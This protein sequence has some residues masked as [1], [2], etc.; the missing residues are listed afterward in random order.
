MLSDEPAVSAGVKHQYGRGARLFIPIRVAEVSGGH[1]Q[2][3]GR[4]T[5]VR[6]GFG[7][8]QEGRW[9][10]STTAWMSPSRGIVRDHSLKSI[11]AAMIE[12]LG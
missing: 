11:D 4:P 10:R 7:I 12:R 9:N 3:S 1:C 2:V 5:R 6:R 8:E